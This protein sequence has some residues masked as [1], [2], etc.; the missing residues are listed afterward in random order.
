MDRTTELAVIRRAYAKQVLAEVQ[1]DDP[2]IE[3]AFAAVLRE[4]FLGPGPWLIPRW[5]VGPVPTPTSDPT[6]LYVDSVVSIVAERGLNNGLPSAH[7]KWIA[8]ARPKEGEYVV[9]VGTGTGYY[10]AILAHL[11]GPSGQ[12]TGIEFDP[13]LAARAQSNLS[14]LSNVRVVQ[15]DGAQMSFDP[16]DI[17]YVCAGA[18][19]PVDVWLDGMAEGGRLM[20]PLT[21]NEAFTKTGSSDSLEKHGAMFR[22]E[23]H[24]SDFTA[25]W[26]SPAAFIPCESA[27]DARSEAALA[28][29]LA[30]GGWERVTRFFRTET[31]ADDR[32]WL[33]APGWSLAYC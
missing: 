24:A 23:R 28:D 11:V 8:S 3:A 4:D 17:I 10:T 32:C 9:H 13:L 14:S 18:T 5:M 20:V 33:R 25:Q 15:G 22:F 30:R 29:A 21:T 6:Y 2:Q 7:A 19:R 31:I 26:I 12:V 16:A 1:V 27:R